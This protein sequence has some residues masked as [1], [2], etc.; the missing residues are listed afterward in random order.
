MAP[1]A[2]S[3]CA[4]C[5]ANWMFPPPPLGIVLHVR[6]KQWIKQSLVPTKQKFWAFLIYNMVCA[7]TTTVNESHK[8][9][10]R[11]WQHLG[12]TSYQ[13]WGSGKSPRAKASVSFCTPHPELRVADG[14]REMGTQLSRSLPSEATPSFHRP[15]V[16]RTRFCNVCPSR[17][18]H[19]QM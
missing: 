13:T 14:G 19:S 10:H 4:V 3:S 11:L 2:H 1:A 9:T 15:L 7:T 12:G 18:S 6:V 5:E 8:N 17:Q 16:H